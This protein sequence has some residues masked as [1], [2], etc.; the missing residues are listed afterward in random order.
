MNKIQTLENGFRIITSE[1]PYMESVSIGVWIGVGGRYET[2]KLSG[3][4]HFIE[5]MLFKGT[6]TRNASQLKQAIEGIGGQFN[7]FTGE[8]V[9]CYLVKVPSKYMDL[10]VDI[11]SDMIIN[12]AISTH[13]LEKEKNVICE[14]IKMYKD[15]PSSYVQELLA[16][17]MWEKHPLGFPL[18]GS[19][20]TVL[21]MD[22]KMLLDFKEKYYCS[23]NIAFAACGKIKMKDFQRAV[24][25]SCD[26]IKVGKQQSSEIY[27]NTQKNKRYTTFFKNTEQTHVEFGFK[28][29]GRKSKD[30]YAV[31]LLNIILGGNMSSRLFEELREKQGLCYDVSSSAKKYD[32]IGVFSVHAGVDNN[33]VKQTI[34]TVIEQLE[35]LKTSKVPDAELKR[36][37]EFFKGQFLLMLESTGSRMLWLGEKI[38]TEGNIPKIKEVLSQIDKI[39]ACDLQRISK[40]I[41]VSKNMNFAAIGPERIL[42]KIDLNS[43]LNC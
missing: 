27:K 43:S 9:T 18:A 8:D 7:G 41:F 16:E 23:G 2:P 3:I 17:I 22:Q 11:L 28:S 40:Q 37:K 20:K 38:L 34:D 15:Q 26:K 19:E 33:K 4:S 25:F 5:H 12:P 29:V 24:K 30:R 36:A 13:E 10:G 42:K 6:K 35:I 1:M 32:E 39:S 21:S 31:N 14:E